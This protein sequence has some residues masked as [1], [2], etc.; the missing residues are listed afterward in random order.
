MLSNCLE[1]FMGGRGKDDKDEL[2]QQ[3]QKKTN[4]GKILFFNR[5]G[6]N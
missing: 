4:E 5:V 6:C 1:Y 3:Q 2:Q